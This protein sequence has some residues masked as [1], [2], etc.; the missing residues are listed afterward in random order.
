MGAL[1]G[2]AVILGMG[3]G[4]LSLVL[5]AGLVLSAALVLRVSGAAHEPAPA[6]PSNVREE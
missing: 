3:Y 1:V 4:A 2:G 5:G 6:G